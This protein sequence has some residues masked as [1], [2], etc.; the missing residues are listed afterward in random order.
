[1]CSMWRVLSSKRQAS[2]EVKS[3]LGIGGICRRK[4]YFIASALSD[5]SKYCKV[6]KEVIRKELETASNVMGKNSLTS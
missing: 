1:M 2:K 4:F 3:W 6:M 5:I